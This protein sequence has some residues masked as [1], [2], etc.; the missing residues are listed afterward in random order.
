M[1][2]L[3]TIVTRISCRSLPACMRRLTGSQSAVLQDV[4]ADHSS[5]RQARTPRLQ[6][7]MQRQSADTHTHIPGPSQQGWAE[8]H[9]RETALQDMSG[10]LQ[11][12]V[13]DSQQQA[14]GTVQSGTKQTGPFAPGVARQAVRQQSCQQTSA[15]NSAVQSSRQQPPV[16]LPRQQSS[17]MYHAHQPGGHLPLPPAQHA[18]R[19]DRGLP[20]AT[21]QHSGGDDHRL[22]SV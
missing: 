4:L 19:D 18:Q 10:Q 16:V 7:H 20:S 1:Q 5:H 8:Q 13:H 11:T 9:Q 2:P 21:H 17:E 12:E 22:G 3:L 6:Q 15:G 14:T